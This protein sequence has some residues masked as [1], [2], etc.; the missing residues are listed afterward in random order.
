MS[1]NYLSQE[2]YS[3]IS[4]ELARLKSEG[5]REIA[6]RLKQSKELGDLSENSDY[7][8]ARE[9]QARL[10][11]RIGELDE[12]LATSTIIHK[13]GGAASIRVGSRIKV[14]KDGK[15]IE[16][17]IVGSSEADPEKGFISNESPVGREFIGKK[18]GDEISVK[19]P[20]G[21][22]HYSI[23]SIE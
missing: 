13:A 11:T 3:E 12:T 9:E 15:V 14:K 20:K 6:E 5:R 10:E 4:A 23:I 19:T 2:R 18:G 7:Q 17:F 8:E 16:Y 21:E 1:T 22:V